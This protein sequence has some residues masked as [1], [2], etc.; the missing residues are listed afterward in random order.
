MNRC[1]VRLGFLS[2]LVLVAACVATHGPSEPGRTGPRIR[3][4]PHNGIALVETT[5]ELSAPHAS[6]YGGPSDHVLTPIESAI[7][8]KLVGLPVRHNP[9]LSRMSRELARSSPGQN[10][11]PP[12][13]LILGLMAWSGL[14]DQSPHLKLFEMSPDP[15][16]CHTKAAKACASAIDSL[17][18]QVGAALPTEGPIEF[19][20]GVSKV[21][22]DTTRM[23]VALLT[24]AVELD[25]IPSTLRMGEEATLRGRLLGGRTDPRI[26]IIDSLGGWTSVPPRSKSRADF[27]S[28]IHCG[29]VR[30]PLQIEVLAEGTH[31]P[32]V[33]A[34]FPLYCEDEPPR[35]L[36]VLSEQIDPSVTADQIADAN[37][38][39]VNDE[40]RRR[41]LTEL[42]WS[43]RAAAIAQG[44]SLDMKRHR[45]FGHRSPRT[46]GPSD[47]FERAHFPVA[48]LRE[49][50]AQGYGPKVIHDGLMDSPGH[51]LNILATDVTHVGIGVAIGDPAGES[52]TARSIFCTQNYFRIPGADA[53]T[54]ARMIPE[55]K[56]RVDR[57]RR[58]AGRSAVVWVQALEDTAAE[59]G[60]TEAKDRPPKKGWDAHLQGLGFRSVQ[61]HIA[62]S[63]DFEALVG[64]DLFAEDPLEAG[65]YV[66]RLKAT[67]DAQFLMVV[68]VGER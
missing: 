64:I 44:H 58:A 68:V 49:N 17:A 30:G 50:V 41:G 34:N 31:G 21:S 9:A 43:D 29:P 60:R 16:G 40:R 26:E 13:A 19:G 47:R 3:S 56:D 54:E 37:F 8:D 5:I 11:I 23:V 57:A 24:V 61:S 65:I 52:D 59:L 14:V 51:R 39:Y 66:Q 63:G 38:Q 25:P 33:A 6:Q 15:A 36:T 46:G 20:V 55:M 2:V 4:D 7:A 1:R 10:S 18:T 32:E 45:F 28:T 27:E 12:P 22:S 42:Q 53:P 48:S 62:R 35:R 67:G